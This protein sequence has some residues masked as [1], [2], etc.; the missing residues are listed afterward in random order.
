MTN[1]EL[2]R[3]LEA[4][5]ERCAVE[6]DMEKSFAEERLAEDNRDLRR[7]Q[8]HCAEHMGQRAASFWCAKHVRQIDVSDWI[9]RR[10][11]GR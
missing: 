5:R 9:R 3:L 6:C 7:T 10:E 8:V 4:F 1:A 2:V 11:E